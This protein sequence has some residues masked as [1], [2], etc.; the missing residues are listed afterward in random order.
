MLPDFSNR[1][2]NLIKA[3]EKTIAPAI[4][5]ENDLAREQAALVIGHLKMLDQQWDG[6]YLFEKGC[7]DNMRSLAVRL[8][9]G[10]A[11]GATTLAA[12]DELVSLIDSLPSTLPLSVKQI[13]R[14]TCQI[15]L[16]VDALINGAYKDGS[17][18]YQSLL[19][20]TVLD[21]NSK[22]SAR[23]RVWFRANNLDPDPSDLCSMEE[24][25]QTDIYAF[26]SQQ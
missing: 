10:A 16:A 8:T 20:N 5:S 9:A 11:G 17:N 23:E 21:Y 14:L 13:N 6:L 7:F 25:L 3:M 1:L 12:A 15:G 19:T 2:N 4:D 18:D 26:S 22:Q 24:M